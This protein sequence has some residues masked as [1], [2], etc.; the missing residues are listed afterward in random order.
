MHPMFSQSEPL[1][2]D[3]DHDVESIATPNA[4]INES[5]HTLGDGGTNE[6][7][8]NDVGSTSKMTSGV[9]RA[10]KGNKNKADTKDALIAR[11][12]GLVDVTRSVGLTVAAPIVPP[13]IFM[14]S[15]AVH[16]LEK[17]PDIF[18]DADMY[19]FATLYLI[20]LNNRI[21]FMNL[22]DDRKVSWLRKRYM[23]SL[24]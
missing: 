24:K 17:F 6:S 15:E 11:F 14:L 5:V 21:V 7:K 1:S 19:D 23:D 12:D 9:K 8:G 4:K 22:P 18:D 2:D 10:R 20:N 3:D 13:S 16:E